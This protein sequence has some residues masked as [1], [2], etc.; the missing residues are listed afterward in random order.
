MTAVSVLALSAAAIFA[1]KRDTGFRGQNQQQN[2]EA[3]AESELS[4]TDEEQMEL[5]LA[6]EQAAKDLYESL[7]Q[8]DLEKSARIL[9][10][11]EEIFVTLFYDT[12]GAE[13]WLFDGSDFTD[14]I[15][16]KGMVLT[17]SATAFKGTFGDNGPMGNCVA[18]QAFHLEEPRYDY[19]I[20]NWENGKMNGKGQTGYCYY[21][22]APQGEPEEVVRR[23]V[24]R[25]DRLD[26][27]VLY[28]TSS[29]K[30]GKTSWEIQVDH[31]AVVIDEGW[32]KDGESE[33]Y[34]LPS[35]QD[36]AKAYAI[37]EKE[38]A[39]SS[40]GNVLVWGRE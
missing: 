8:G 10:E 29:L 7:E 9:V 20:G 28:S 2:A 3:E 16:G 11:R 38:A 17:S 13:K 40:W 14:E 34:Y 33:L 37:S 18:F 19:S 36:Q 4:K 6:E 12:L 24:F 22:G 32:S 21:E 30:E 31:G 39:D 26:G 23:G 25:E 5:S 27:Q 35:L 1:Y 15:R